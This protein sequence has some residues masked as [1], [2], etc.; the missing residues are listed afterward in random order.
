MK[1]KMLAAAIASVLAV[2]S[3]FAAIDDAGM[4]YTSASEG[5][6]GSFRFGLFGEE[7]NDA[8]TTGSVS[9]TEG[10]RLGVQGDVD[11]GHGNTAFYRLEWEYDYN[12]GSFSPSDGKNAFRARLGYG[13][14][15]GR[16]GSVQFGRMWSADYDYVFSLADVTNNVTGN[17]APR[18]RVSN[19]LRYDSPDIQGFNFAIQLHADDGVGR[20]TATAP[21]VAGP[22]L[23]TDADVPDAGGIT[24]VDTYNAAS[25][26]LRAAYRRATGL[27]EVLNGADVTGLRIAAIEAGTVTDP[28]DG[29]EFD[30][31]ILAAGYTIRGVN[32]GATYVSE[33]APDSA[34]AGEDEDITTWGIGGSYGQD[35]WKVAYNYGDT[36]DADHEN[37]NDR[38]WHAFSGQVGFDKVTLRAVYET[39]ETEVG[40]G[41]FDQDYFTLEAQY[42]FSSKARTYFNYQSNDLEDNPNIVGSQESDSDTF[43]VA[44]RVDF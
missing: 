15:K 35:N 10:T 18:F 42:N 38:S 7:D 27:E 26:E 34:A 33:K 11:I 20:T 3:A 4:K 41:S 23:T 12:V 5:F 1:K 2:P 43:Y 17:F 40:F 31:Y 9:R 24:T 30:R 36:S 32:L 8:N 6:Y 39:R 13:G 28:D 29:N 21:E 22:T 14:L 16:F 19:A 44:Y 25:D 37:G